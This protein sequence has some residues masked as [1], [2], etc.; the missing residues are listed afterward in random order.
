MSELPARPTPPRS[1]RQRCADWIEWFGAG[2]LV[3]TVV[4][5]VVV[6]AGGAW[7]LRTPPLPTEARLPLASTTTTTGTTVTGTIDPASRDTGDAIP[8]TEV[9]PGQALVVHIAGAVH[10]PGVHELPAASR[11][12]DAVE[13]AGGQ[14]ADA[15]L[16]RLNLAAPLVDG[17]RVFVPVVGGT[18]PPEPATAATAT[19]QHPA[20]PV[21]LNRAT[22]GELDALPGIGPATATAI[23]EHRDRN[24]PFATVDDL[25]Q[26]PGIGPAKL[27]AIRA[28]VTV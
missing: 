17:Q 18:I 28:L 13:A 8:L 1:L 4:A 20:G 21:D 3:L 11:V 19:T 27:E 23:V 15:D 12:I 10:D 16:D 5:V 6:V 7:L 9:Q 2:R 25:E 24:G 14:T 26:V 22:A